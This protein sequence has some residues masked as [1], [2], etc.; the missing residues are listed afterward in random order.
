MPQTIP[1]APGENNGNQT[2]LIN[3]RWLL[4]MNDD[5]DVH[6]EH[7]LI[8]EGGRIVG[9]LP[10]KE[11][12]EAYPQLPVIDRRESILMPGLINAH[13]HLAMNLLKGFADDLPLQTWLENHIWPAEAAHL[14]PEFVRDGTELALAESILAGVTMVNDMYFFADTTAKVCEIA[15]V[16]AT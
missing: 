3:A 7:S 4:T 6:L 15:G 8:V 14:S 1:P 13:T 5:N 10:W 11:A 12:T 2:F 9:I 16:K